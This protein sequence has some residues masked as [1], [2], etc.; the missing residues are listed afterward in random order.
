MDQRISLYTQQMPLKAVGMSGVFN[1]GEAKTT[2]LK[3]DLN[4]AFSFSNSGKFL[5]LGGG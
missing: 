4:T 5:A 2:F 1:R 3:L